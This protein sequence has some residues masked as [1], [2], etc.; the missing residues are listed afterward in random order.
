M[1]KI[2]VNKTNWVFLKQRDKGK[3][4]MGSWR[5]VLMKTMINKKK[6][7]WKKIK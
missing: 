3:N 2:G 6:C 1:I 5:L 7:Q 4:R